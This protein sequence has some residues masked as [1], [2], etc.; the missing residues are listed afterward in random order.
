MRHNFFYTETIIKSKFCYPRGSLK[1]EA[2]DTSFSL[3]LSK[4][5]KRDKDGAQMVIFSGFAF[6]NYKSTTQMLFD[7]F[8]YIKIGFHDANCYGPMF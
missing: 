6:A 3:S 1:R 7:Y 8:L 2:R 5:K 4:K